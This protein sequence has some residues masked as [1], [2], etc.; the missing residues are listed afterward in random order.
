MKNIIASTA[1]L[2]SFSQFL[3]LFCCVV[4][5]ATGIIAILTSVGLVSSSGSTFLG[6]LSQVLH[7]WRETILITSISLISLSWGLWFLKWK[8][9]SSSHH[10]SEEGGCGCKAKTKKPTFLMVATALLAF[11]VVYAHSLH[12]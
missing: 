5:T 7:P 2:T 3:C 1:V 12:G 8:Q 9:Q 4:P 11:N 10:G 6:D